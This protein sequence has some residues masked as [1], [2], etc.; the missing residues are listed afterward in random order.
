[1]SHV[2]LPPGPRGLP[3]L[4]VAPF[5]MQDPYG[6]PPRLARRYG[7]VVNIPM[8]G[9]RV[10][11]INHPEHIYHVTNLHADRYTA[12]PDLLKEAFSDPP[13]FPYNSFTLGGEPWKRMRQLLKPVF[14][15]KGL[16]RISN[17]MISE[18][19]TQVDSWSR[20]ADTG[21]WVDI[22]PELSVLTM[23]IFIG[24]F[25][26]G[27][28]ARSDVEQSVQAFDEL[29][30]ALGWR[31]LMGQAPAWLP[32]P[33]TRKGRAA[34]ARIADSLN[35][36]IAARRH[37]PSNTS[38]VLDVLLSARFDDGVALSDAQLRSELR[39]L[40]LA[41]YETTAA[42]LSWTVALLTM[43]PEASGAAL[44]EVDTVGHQSVRYTDLPKLTWLRAC[45]DE[46]QRL[47]GHPF[48]G[49]EAREDDELGGYLIP[50]GASVSFSAYAMHRDPRFWR[51]PERFN[52][53]R[54]ETEQI[55]KHVFAPYSMG[56]HRCLG[57][58]LAN[59]VG[60][61]TLAAMLQRYRFEVPL[62]Y[63]PQH[64]YKFGNPVKNGVPV[65]LH[66]R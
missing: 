14:S 61:L 27:S 32:R 46:S 16:E 64:K 12:K 57:M 13:D 6:Y 15:P 21:E 62:G 2:P 22:Q 48:N 29:M 53:G 44:A 9:P 51:E 1:M 65:R 63:E 55:D 30:L 10:I 37:T 45:F 66:S 59:V 50:I 42:A 26:S 47:Q 25:L 52:P 40:I 43:N 18:I 36:A 11:Y 31:I 28:T 8:P 49:R 35:Q 60:V 54:F 38:D 5:V 39:G 17:T 19:E 20:W 33:N 34:S 3:G 41:G 7:D 58:H 4:G 56:P 24:C 23:S